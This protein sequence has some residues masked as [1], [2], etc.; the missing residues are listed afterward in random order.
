VSL[1]ACR[2]VPFPCGWNSTAIECKWYDDALFGCPG[3][4]NQIACLVSDVGCKRKIIYLFKGVW[5]YDE[6]DEFGTCLE[7]DKFFLDEDTFWETWDEDAFYEE[8]TKK[9]F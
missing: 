7:D 2:G 4:I 3:A 6:T 9:F 1:T 5:K 8:F